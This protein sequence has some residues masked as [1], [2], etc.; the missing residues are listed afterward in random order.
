MLVDAIYNL[1]PSFYNNLPLPW[2]L[3]PVWFDL[4]FWD[5][6]PVYG[7]H[8]KHNIIISCQYLVRRDFLASLAWGSPVE[9]I[10]SL[11]C[12]AHTGRILDASFSLYVS[13]YHQPIH[14]QLYCIAIHDQMSVTLSHYEQCP[15]FTWS[16]DTKCY[17]P[18]LLWVQ[19]YE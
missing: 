6:F 2:N 17:L 19:P 11:L 12:D 7:L 4:V 18:L 16:R 8:S 13:G 1:R 3:V 5:M 15:C 10:P 9:S 14:K